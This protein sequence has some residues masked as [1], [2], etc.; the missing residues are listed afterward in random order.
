MVAARKESSGFTYLGALLLVALMGTLLG[1][2]GEVWRTAQLREAERDLRFV[3][4]EFS[5]AIGR[6]Y[7]STPGPV[8]KYPRSLKDLLYDDRYP[9]TRRYLRRVYRDPITN[10]DDWGLIEAPEGGISGV[11]SRSKDEP[12]GTFVSSSSSAAESPTATTTPGIQVA[13]DQKEEKKLR[14]SDWVFVYT[15]PP[16]PPSSGPKRPPGGVVLPPGGTS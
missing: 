10:S 8:K 5:R 16:P 2:A 3:G 12:I 15:P 4:G 1:A 13:K 7:E 6:Y 11:Y 9:G 14:Y